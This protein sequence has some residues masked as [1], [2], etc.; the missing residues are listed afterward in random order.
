MFIKFT[1]STCMVS[2]NDRQK[3]YVTLASYSSMACN[4]EGETIMPYY[5]S[6]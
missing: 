5:N 2:Y 4:Y 3:S 6:L 1:M